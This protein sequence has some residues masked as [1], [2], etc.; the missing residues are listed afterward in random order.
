MQPTPQI[1]GK[2]TLRRIRQIQ[3]FTLVWM[4]TEAALS[5]VAAWRAHSPVLG[6]FGGDSVVELLSAA[7]VLWRF[8]AH[9]REDAERLASRV[10]GVLLFALAACVVVASASSLLAYHRP[11]PSFLGIVVLLAAVV[12]MPWLARQKRHLSA[13]TQSAALRADAAESAFCAY[14]AL[15]A[16]IGLAVNAIWKVSWADPVAALILTPL[17]VREGREVLQGRACGCC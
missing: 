9:A 5:L 11:K 3:A 15:I 6:A 8:R 14:L 4:T 12:I 17:I 16:L 2:D 7:I 10:A 13:I 1:M